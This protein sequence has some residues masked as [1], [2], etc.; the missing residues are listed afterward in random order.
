MSVI[1]FAKALGKSPIGLAV[2]V[3]G[4]SALGIFSYKR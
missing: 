1:K 2:T 3:V 4:G